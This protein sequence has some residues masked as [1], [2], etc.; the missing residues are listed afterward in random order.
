MQSK[1]DP[2]AKRQKTDSTTPSTANNL[3]C[4]ICMEA[5][6]DEVELLDHS[7]SQCTKGAWKICEGC[8]D[9]CLSKEC[10]MCRQPYAPMQLFPY[11]SM[12]E[13]I[14]L[15]R[16]R[17]S[18]NPENLRTYIT[19]CVTSSYALLWK[20]I[21]GSNT[22]LWQNIDNTDNENDQGNME[23]IIPKTVDAEDEDWRCMRVI[24]T[25]PSTNLKSSTFAKSPSM[26]N[27][28]SLI[29]S[30]EVFLFVFFKR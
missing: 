13:M 7:C 28:V 26:L 8:D 29:I 24:L 9:G 21:K 3:L 2:A 20:L 30:F 18:S 4:V 6:S 19:K 16:D 17:C 15:V 12:E 10:P 11:P 27:K 23:F 22:A 5:D 14:M 25:M 1:D